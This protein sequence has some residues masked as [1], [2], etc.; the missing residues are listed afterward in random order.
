MRPLPALTLVST[1]LLIGLV[2]PGLSVQ[3]QTSAYQVV[4]RTRATTS[5]VQVQVA[6][7]RAT[8]ISFSQTNETIAFMGKGKLKAMPKKL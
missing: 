1:A 8:S 3:A 4:D 5:A 2:S 6:P 7:G